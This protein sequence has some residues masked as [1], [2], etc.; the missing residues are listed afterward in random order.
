MKERILLTHEEFVILS[1]RP[2]V[3]RMLDQLKCRTKLCN[4]EVVSLLQ[5]QSKSSDV[6]G[7]K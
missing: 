7:K 6:V 5:Q 2:T 1:V 3:N 4:I